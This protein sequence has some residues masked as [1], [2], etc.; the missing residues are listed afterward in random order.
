VQSLGVSVLQYTLPL[1]ITVLVACTASS[2]VCSTADLSAVF[3]PEQLVQHLN[4]SIQQQP[5]LSYAGFGLQQG[6]LPLNVSV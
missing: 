2:R 1:D 5:V 6:V 4:V 3:V